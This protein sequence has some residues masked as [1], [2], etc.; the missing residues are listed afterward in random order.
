MNLMSSVKVCRFLEIY[1][2]PLC[3]ACVF[4]LYWF[5]VIY[6]ID[7]YSVFNTPRAWD[8]THAKYAHSEMKVILKSSHCFFSE[9]ITL[10][11]GV[12]SQVH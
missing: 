5:Y 2:N 3:A 1:G 8:P 9:I 4:F 11:S 7:F 12:G 6:I 10:V